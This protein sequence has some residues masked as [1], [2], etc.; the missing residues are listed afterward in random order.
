MAVKLTDEQRGETRRQIEDLL[1]A[2]NRSGIDGLIEF[3]NTSDFYNAPCSTEHHLDTEG[4]LAKHSL[5][6]LTLLRDRIIQHG[7]QASIPEDSVIVSGLCHDLCKVG[8][9]ERGFKWVKPSGTWEKQETWVV[10]DKLPL[11]H[12]EKSVA[13]CQDYIRLTDLEKM[14]IRWHMGAF[15][16]GFPDDYGMRCAFNDA[17]NNL[18][19]VLITTADFEATRVL[20][21]E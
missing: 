14:A 11:G 5:N 10:K 17:M 2:T 18:L 6:V 16:A 15:T 12:G 19:V 13:V 3:L 8:F 4:G 20:E 9:Y 7:L 21:R 1:L